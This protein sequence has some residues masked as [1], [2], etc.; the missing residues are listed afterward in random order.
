MENYRKLLILAAFVTAILLLW[1]LVAGQDFLTFEYLKTNHHTLRNYVATHYARSAL[2][3]ILL[4]L[5]TSLVVPGAL[6]LTV[7]GGA[8][9]G[10]LPTALFVNIG[11]TV[12]SVVAFYVTRYLLAA[13]VQERYRNELVR[14]HRELEQHGY[15]YL[16]TL[17]IIP[18]L[19]AFLVNYLAGLT[20]VPPR[21][22]IWTTSLGVLPGALI[23]AYAGS[24][25]ARL[26]SAADIVSLPM[27]AV[28][29][30]M[31]LFSLL[32][33]ILKHSKRLRE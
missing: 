33:V 25:L 32:P 31:G 3:F 26:E 29:L 1:L 14:F 4:Y 11:A 6:A 23:Y 20:R 30:M 21:T 15:S 18:I 5:S 22:F 2:I 17:R 7:A 28:F 10:T 19:P 8:L 27:M 9:F 24:R 13:W 16:L 12:G